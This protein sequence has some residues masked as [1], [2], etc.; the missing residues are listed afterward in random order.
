MEHY[1]SQSSS[2]GEGNAINPGHCAEAKPN[3]QRR[4]IQNRKNQRARRM[5]MR[6]QDPGSVQTSLPFHVKRWRLDEFD[7]SALQNA[8]STSKGT[9]VSKLVST[10][11]RAGIPAH[12]EPS[13]SP[14]AIIFPLS[15]DHLLHLVQYNVFR[16]FICNKRILNLFQSCS[17]DPLA[18]SI[19]PISRLYHDDAIVYPLDSNLPR[20]LVPTQLQLT[21]SH[22][23]WISMFPFPHIRDNLIKHQGDF[24][25]WNLLEDLIGELMGNRQ[26]PTRPNMPVTMTISDPKTN[27]ARH[28]KA[29][30]YE[31]EVTGDRRGLIVW[32]E[33]SDSSSWEATPG[34]LAKWSFLWEG[35][36]EL[37]ESTNR[38]RLIRGEEPIRI[39]E[40]ES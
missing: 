16:A 12:A 15:T 20:A 8:S 27:K 25:H 6:G 11:R 9:R 26:S 34:F 19:C 23:I 40:L 31:D 29:K 10:S 33:P 18:P 1:P 14:P 2:S 28:P 38:W 35:C 13:L 4:K 39:S 21:R 5:R 3:K 32:G 7:D 30:S 24:D 17:Q 36:N 22:S 37:L